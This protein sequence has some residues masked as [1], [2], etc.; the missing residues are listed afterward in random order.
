MVYGVPTVAAGSGDEL[1]IVSVEFAVS[2]KFFVTDCNCESVVVTEKVKFP[3][4]G[5]APDRSPLEDRVSHVG[6]EAAIQVYPGD[7]PEAVNCREY[8]V[9]TVAAGRGE[10]VLI[11]S[12]AVRGKTKLAVALCPSTSFTLMGSVTDPPAGGTPVKSP[13]EVRVNQ[14]GKEDELQV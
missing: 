10:T 4:V 2:E 6:S 12:G 11:A 1:M 3:A 5:G 7:P 8:A 13:P 9:P 14:L